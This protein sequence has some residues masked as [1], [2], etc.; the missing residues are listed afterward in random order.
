[1]KN[2]YLTAII[3]MLFTISGCSKNEDEDVKEEVVSEK[4]LD[5][6]VAGKIYDT[7][8][9]INNKGGYANNITIN[10]I[11]SIDIYLTSEEVG[12]D[13]PSGTKFPAIITTPRAIGTH[14]SKTSIFFKDPKSTDFVSVSNVTVEIISVGTTVVGKVMG[15][16]SNSNINGKFEVPYC[17]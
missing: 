8:F 3:L 16:S 7:T 4:L 9:K 15:S 17:K 12:C 6:P 1:M 2:L 5:T 11:E 14:T 13:A 10:G